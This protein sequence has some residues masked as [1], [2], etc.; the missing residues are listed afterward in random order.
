M[1]LS[2]KF[3]S[4]FAGNFFYLLNMFYQKKR[5]LKY[6]HLVID[7]FQKQIAETISISNIITNARLI[8][9]L[10]VS[11]PDSSVCCEAK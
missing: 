3:C 8:A 5:I 7:L 1:L 2:F 11:I 6:L 10:D 4:Y 9:I